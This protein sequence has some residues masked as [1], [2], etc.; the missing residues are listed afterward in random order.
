MLFILVQSRELNDK[1]DD[2]EDEIINS[3]EERKG[4]ITKG[5]LVGNARVPFLNMG[6]ILSIFTRNFLK[7]N[8]RYR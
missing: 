7:T 5:S 8:F 3:N 2:G 4:W 6:N 1:V